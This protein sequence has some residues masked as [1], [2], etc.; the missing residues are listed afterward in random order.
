[1]QKTLGFLT[2]L[3]VLVL[4][5]GALW[6]ISTRPSPPPTYNQPE[7]PVT[8]N[9]QDYPKLQ[10]R[11]VELIGASD[12]AAFAKEHGFEQDF[13]DGK[14]VVVIEATSSEF[15]EELRWAVEA[16]DGKVE[17]DYENQLQALVPIKALLKLAKHPHIEFIRLPVRPKP[18]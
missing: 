6:Y 15:L 4:V 17:T 10:E 1:M 2:A 7:P 8:L 12:P 3:V 18:D 16:L 9:P 5:A 11:L 13:K 14:I